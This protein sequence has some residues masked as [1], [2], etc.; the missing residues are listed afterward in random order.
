VSLRTSE[1]SIDSASR[2]LA[3]RRIGDDGGAAPGPGILF[4]H[5]LHSDQIGY[6][7]RANALASTLGA[8]CLT[9]DLGGHGR[10]E[11]GRE[12]LSLRDHLDEA[13]AAYD[14]L[15]DLGDVDRGRIGV[16][17]ASYGGY[18]AALLVARRAVRR[19]FLR[20]PALY[21][22]DWLEVPLRLRGRVDGPPP[23][24]AA[25]TGLSRFD[26]DVLVL[27]SGRD[28]AIP[29]AVVEAYLRASPRAR[30]EVIRDATHSLSEP[31]WQAEFVRLL[32]EWFTPL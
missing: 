9:F 22:D 25:L 4:L 23:T 32:Q 17:G 5:G 19:L 27:E 20:A 3:A 2:R 18:L 10:S 14:A 7:A 26:G 24:S 1:I 15:S 30:H 29:H 12:D 16:C 28:E 8:T 13:V 11:G 21:P 6:E 31:A